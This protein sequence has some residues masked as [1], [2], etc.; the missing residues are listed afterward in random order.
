MKTIIVET[1]QELLSLQE[2]AKTERFLLFPLFSEESHPLLSTPIVVFAKPLNMDELYVIS[3]SHSECMNI[4]FD[5]SIF[6][7]SFVYNKKYFDI[8]ECVDIESM[9]YVQNKECVTDLYK[10][11]ENWQIYPIYKIVD[12]ISG[13]ITQFS[14]DCL[15]FTG[16]QETPFRFINEVTL[17]S[18]VAIEKNGLRVDDKFECK[19]LIHDGYVY[20]QYNHLTT[21]GRPSNRYG[22][23]NYNALNTTDGSR[24]PFISRFGDNGKL[25]MLDYDGYHVRLIAKLMDYQ[26]PSESVHIFFARQYFNTDEI[27]H[28]M[29]DE[30]KKITFR[31][32]YGGLL[33]EYKHVKF[34]SQIPFL[35]NELWTQYKN[36]GVMPS[37]ISKIPIYADSKTKLFNYIIQNY[38]TEQNMLVLRKIIKETSSYKSVPVLYTYDS[39]LF[40]TVESEVENYVREVRRIMEIDGQFP[41]KLYYGKN[42]NEMVKV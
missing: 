14:T 33:E 41:T 39:I 19:E 24:T 11:H 3:I 29:Y 12:K 17:P 9:Y 1:S 22:G 31:M 23:V 25:V 35:I 20:S 18:L 36:N 30:S 15:K 4:P 13:M 34:F 28:E 6:K 2:L 42:Y 10:Y 26:L 32:L 5:F 21:T 27:T 16:E 8:S 7:K 40:D 38:E 37:V